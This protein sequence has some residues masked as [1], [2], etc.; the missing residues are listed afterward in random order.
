MGVQ[1]VCHD[2]AKIHIDTKSSD[3]GDFNNKLVID[4]EPIELKIE[5]L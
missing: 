1:P 5:K 3:G 2:Q 4:T